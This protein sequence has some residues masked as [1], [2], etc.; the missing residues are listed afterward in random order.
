MNITKRS[1]TVDAFNANVV[2]NCSVSVVSHSV[3]SI[4]FFVSSLMARSAGVLPKASIAVLF[5]PFLISNSQILMQPAL[6]ASC[7]GTL[8]E[9]PPGTLGLAPV[10]RNR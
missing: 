10:I 2:S 4:K 7:K 6:A 3:S 9:S 1:G 5:A 8:F